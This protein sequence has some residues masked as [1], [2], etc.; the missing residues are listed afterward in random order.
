M[1]KIHVY[2]INGN[3]CINGVSTR[4]IDCDEQYED[5]RD[6]SDNSF[7][8][9]EYQA[10]RNVDD[11][12]KYARKRL[13]HDRYSNIARIRKAVQIIL[14]R[15]RFGLKIKKVVRMETGEIK[16]VFKY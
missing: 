11:T 8:L 2:D 16:N 10:G 15:C 13:V 3:A 7:F 1:G 12:Y 14:H 9:H 5:D 6:I 4:Y